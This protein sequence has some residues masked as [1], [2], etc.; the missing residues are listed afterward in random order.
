[1]NCRKVMHAYVFVESTLHG[2]WGAWGAWRM[3]CTLNGACCMG[4]TH[5]MLYGA[6]C[7]WGMAHGVHVAWHR[8]HGVPVELL[9]KRHL[10]ST[11]R[12]MAVISMPLCHNVLVALTRARS[13]MCSCPTMPNLAHGGAMRMPHRTHAHSARHANAAPQSCAQCRTAI[14]MLHP[15]HA[16]SVRHATAPPYPPSHARTHRELRPSSFASTC[17]SSCSSSLETLDTCAGIMI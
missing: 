4:Q 1:M 9:E 7:I 3:G 13:P 14:R 6:R 5:C 16:L 11:R 15:A 17:S 10:Q 2:A 12:I 8:L